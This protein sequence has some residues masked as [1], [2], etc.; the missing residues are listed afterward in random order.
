MRVWIIATGNLHKLE[1][2]QSLLPEDSNQVIG[3]KSFHHVPEVIED[4]NTF[5]GNA[6]KKA[7]GLAE[8]LEEEGRAQAIEVLEPYLHSPKPFEFWALADDSGLEVDALN[9]AP[10]V[11]SARYAAAPG[12]AG[13]APDAD[14]NAKLL[15]ELAPH[16]NRKGRFRCVLAAVKLRTFLNPKP[17][18]Q[19]TGTH[20]ILYFSGSCEGRIDTGASGSQGF[21]YDPLFIP[22][23]YDR[24][25]GELGEEIKSKISHRSRALKAMIEKFSH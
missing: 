14:N 13:N 10:G 5:E 7:L 23:G 19:F 6:A 21:G 18:S 2:I 20:E 1:E 15:K 4:A 17:G 24:S 25:F 11:K 16:S 12:T 9:G 3:L 8:W 22:D